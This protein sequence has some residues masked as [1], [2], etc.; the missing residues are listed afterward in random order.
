MNTNWTTPSR[1]FILAINDLR[2]CLSSGYNAKLVKEWNE[3][4]EYPIS[5]KNTKKIINDFRNYKFYSGTISS[6]KEIKS[7]THLS[8]FEKHLSLNYKCCYGTAEAVET[9]YKTGK[10][11]KN[12]FE[13]VGV[14]HLVNLD[15]MITFF[16]E[17]GNIERY[18]YWTSGRDKADCFYDFFMLIKDIQYKIPV[19]MKRKVWVVAV[20][21]KN[22]PKAKTPFLVH[23]LNVLLYPLK[24]IPSKSVF[25][26]TEYRTVTFR[27]GSVSNGLSIEFHIP[28]RFSFN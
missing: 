27:V 24:Y 21:N 28:K 17:S 13:G 9:Y 16:K 6:P 15:E 20:L 12:N 2:R 4:C 26:M 18:E 11:S 3:K 5:I 10:L 7:K 23:V 19:K 22:E 14:S 1:S 25:K 8:D